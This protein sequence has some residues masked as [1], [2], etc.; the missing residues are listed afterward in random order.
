MTISRRGL[1]DGRGFRLPTISVRPG[2]PNRAASG[3]MSS[4]IREPLNGAGGRLPGR[5]RDYRAFLP[6]AAQDASRT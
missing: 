1:V 3:F 6:V 2:K 4:I 5:I